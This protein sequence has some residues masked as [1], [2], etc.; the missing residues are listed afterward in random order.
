MTATRIHPARLFVLFAMLLGIS[1][2][3]APIADAADGP[4][5]AEYGTVLNLS[6]KQRMLS[7]KMS[8]EVML[9]AL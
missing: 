7:Q 5:A 2:Y 1:L 3:H 9:V 8:K 4:T 6:G